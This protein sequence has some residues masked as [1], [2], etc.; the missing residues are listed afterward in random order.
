MLK[1]GLDVSDN[2]NQRTEGFSA[3]IGMDKMEFIKFAVLMQLEKM[4][5]MMDERRKNGSP[6]SKSVISETSYI[7]MGDK[8]VPLE[9]NK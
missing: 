9:N 3:S 6:A 4:E 2:L 7:E 8:K 5:A 1:W